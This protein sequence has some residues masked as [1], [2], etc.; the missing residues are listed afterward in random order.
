MKNKRTAQREAAMQAAAE[1][2]TETIPNAFAGDAHGLL[3]AV[4]KEPAQPMEM[5]L[6][7]AKAA[8]RYETP[9]LASTILNAT[10]TRSLTDLSDAELAVSCT[11]FPWTALCPK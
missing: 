6:D 2:L 4:Y 5:R 11:R 3:V 8:I 10:F 7:A 9:A 1:A